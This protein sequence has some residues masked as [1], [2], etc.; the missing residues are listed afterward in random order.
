V[1]LVSQ[2]QQ[3]S[4]FSLFLSNKASSFSTL[5][6][7]FFCHREDLSFPVIAR[8]VVTKQSR[9]ANEFAMPDL[10]RPNVD[11]RRKCHRSSPSV[12]RASLLWGTFYL[13]LKSLIKIN[14]RAT[15]E[16]L[17]LE[18]GLQFFVTF[19]NEGANRANICGLAMIQDRLN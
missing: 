17:S 7:L 4:T 18:H 14:N 2:A 3:H 1:I 15:L 13:N 12:F 5:V 8:S 6:T 9:S 16:T 19:W 10:S 11:P